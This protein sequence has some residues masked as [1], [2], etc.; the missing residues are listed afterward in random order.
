M[1]PR[2]S[3]PRQFWWPRILLRYKS[4]QQRN[5]NAEEYYVSGGPLCSVSK[6]NPTI[7]V[8]GNYRR[9]QQPQPLFAKTLN[10]GRQGW[11]VEFTAVFRLQWTYLRWDVWNQINQV[12]ELSLPMKFLVA[13]THYMMPPLSRV[14]AARRR[15]Q[16]VNTNDKSR[17][18]GAA[19][20]SHARGCFRRC[21]S[22][23]ALLAVWNK[24]S[25]AV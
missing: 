19:G 4:L 10:L 6:M 9:L 13:N 5:Q 24:I 21:Q 15:S 25:S 11:I 16:H 14:A 12:H 20:D 2:Q 7:R 18:V 1:S 8:C 3:V 23:E 17:A 22:Y